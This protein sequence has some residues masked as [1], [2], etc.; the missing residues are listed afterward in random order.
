MPVDAN[1]PADAPVKDARKE[2]LKLRS[3]WVYRIFV[4]AWIGYAGFYFCRRNISWTPLPSSSHQGWMSGFADLLM[5]FSMGYMCGQLVGGWSADKFGA[6]RTVLFGGLLSMTATALLLANGPV[7]VMMILQ[8]L[9]G[10]GQGFGWPSMMKLFSVWLPRAQFAIGVA[11]W[12]TSYALGSFLAY[13]LATAL[14]TVDAFP[15]STGARLSIAVP[16]CVLLA[17]TLF[18][19]WRVRDLPTDAGLPPSPAQQA[20]QGQA[21]GWR[22]ILRNPE[23]QLLAAIYFFLK[24][25]RYALLFWLPLYI[26]ET[27]RTRGSSALQLS[28]LFELTGFIGAVFASYASEKWF[29]GRRY[30][31]GSVMLFLAAFVFLLHPLV[32]RGEPRRLLSASRSSGFLSSGRMC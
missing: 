18:F 10:F 25:T 2:A 1:A 20:A 27:Q 12:S 13:A 4:A 8:A 24:L 15:A 28:S 22:A 14:S 30:P 23:I 16:C 7:A 29:G 6:R 32:I 31:V 11:W 3:Y 9:N 21:G 19:Y 26:I 17:T 5:V